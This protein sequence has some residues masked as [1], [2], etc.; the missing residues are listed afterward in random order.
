MRQHCPAKL[1]QVM[2]LSRQSDVYFWDAQ[3]I[4]FLYFMKPGATVNSECYI[5][6]L[7][8]LKA[9]IACT[10]SEKRKT[11]FLQHNNARPQDH[12]T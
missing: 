10:R 4:I 1:G 11:F 6:T 9:R 12:T 2:V 7:I 8:K 3:G 5:K